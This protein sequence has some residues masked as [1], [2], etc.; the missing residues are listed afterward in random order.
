MIL[1]HTMRV[2][3]RFTRHH[4]AVGLGIFLLSAARFK[5]VLVS[6]G[7]TGSRVVPLIT[8]DTDIGD[9]PRS[10]SWSALAMR[11]QCRGGFP[12]GRD[13]QLL[14]RRPMRPVTVGYDL[15]KT[16][17]SG[18]RVVLRCR[19]YAV[20]D[21]GMRLRRAGR[22]E[23]D[24][25]SLW[26]RNIHGSS[27]QAAQRWTQAVCGRGAR[28]KRA[29]CVE[30][31]KADCGRGTRLKRAGRAKW[32]RA[33]V[34]EEHDSSG[35]AGQRWTRAV[36]GRVT[37]LRRA[38]YVELDSG[39]LRPRNTAQAGG[40]REGGLRQSVAEGHGS[41]G[42]AAQ[43]W[44][45]AVCGRGT[46]LRRAGRAEVDSG[47]LWPR[48]TAQAGR[49]RRGGLGQSVAEEHGSGGQAAQ[50][51]TQVVYGRGAWLR[52]AG[53]AEVDS[54]SLWPRNTAQAGRP[55]RGGLGQS[56]AEEHDSGGQAA[57]RWTQA[58]CGRGTRLRR[59]GRAEVD[60][61]SL[62]PRGMAQV[63]GCAEWT[64]TDYGRGTRLRRVGRVEVD[65]G[66]LWLRNTAQAG[67]VAQRWTQA[68][69]S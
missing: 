35:Q 40:S 8:S 46:R 31:T 37:R 43:R 10:V 68:Y 56:V 64:R 11:C 22:A 26:P 38:G 4:T 28:L 57:Q 51:W 48:N 53:R 6:D 49:V 17:D 12:K 32:T 23:V 7:G 59:A 44:T 65:L 1:A 25:G 27:G 62:W 60:S 15:S 45:R 41:G 63:G 33:S 5:L 69:C 20:Y 24:S 36:C 52:R 9:V 54:G 19:N 29:G 2:E 14:A 50:R 30:V 67:R 42:Q 3:E 34:A 39:R 58:V 66:S 55:R 47:S 61:G 13:G 16:E 21:R 18:K